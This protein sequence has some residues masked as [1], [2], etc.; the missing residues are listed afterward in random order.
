[1]SEEVFTNCTVG[2]P[3][4]VYVRDGKITRIRPLGIDEGDLKPW[5]IEVGSKK[6]SPHQKVTLAPFTLT[7][8]RRRGRSCFLIFYTSSC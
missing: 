5:I 6:I 1:M 3:I 8:K 4:S 2:G 7:S